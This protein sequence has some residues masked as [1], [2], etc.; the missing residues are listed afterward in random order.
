M[1]AALARYRA[2]ARATAGAV[3]SQRSAGEFDPRATDL[4]AEL[5]SQGIRESLRQSRSVC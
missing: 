5:L 1:R 2:A 4:P 3:A